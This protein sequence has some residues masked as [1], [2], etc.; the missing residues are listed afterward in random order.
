DWTL[1]DTG[2]TERYMS[3]PRDNPGGYQKSA[4]PP[5][6]GKLVG[7][8]LLVHALMDEN[9]HF[10]HTAKLIDALVE[11]NKDF[12]LLLFPG[13]RHGYRSP[14]ARRYAYRRVVDYFVEHL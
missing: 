12:D 8:L 10:E 13:E 4:L 9:V 5:L 6:A 2:Y 3:T 14:A 11:A 7:K 1:Y